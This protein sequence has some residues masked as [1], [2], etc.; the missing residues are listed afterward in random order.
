MKDEK[1]MEKK[2]MGM[3]GIRVQAEKQLAA[4]PQKNDSE[5]T[6]DN[7]RLHKENA[8]LHEQLH[9]WQQKAAHFAAAEEGQKNANKRL[10]ALVHKTAREREDSDKLAQKANAE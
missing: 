7:I 1:A 5:I 6:D 9:T 8:D 3:T 2:T 10:V 4:K